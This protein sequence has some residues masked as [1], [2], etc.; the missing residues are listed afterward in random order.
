SCDLD[1][2]AGSRC[3]VCT[4]GTGVS[5]AEKATKGAPQS[6]KREEGRR[7]VGRDDGTP[8]FELRKLSEAEEVVVQKALSAVARANGEIEAKTLAKALRGSRAADVLQGPLAATKSF[9]I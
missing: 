2:P 7:D 6:G 9:G 3:D 1:D 5:G 8:G 4:G